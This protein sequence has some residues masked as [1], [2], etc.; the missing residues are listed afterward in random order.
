MVELVNTGKK[1]QLKIE[2][3]FNELIQSDPRNR[4]NLEK[5]VNFD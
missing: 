5:E 1:I 4:F 3:H 2:E